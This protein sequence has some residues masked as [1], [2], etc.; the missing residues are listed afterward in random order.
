MLFVDVQCDREESCKL[1]I[2]LSKVTRVITDVERS[3]L[4][5][6]A[7]RVYFPRVNDNFYMSIIDIK[8]WE[9]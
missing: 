9:G 2:P 7:D 6:T 3:D 5:E 4:I 8:A 1:L